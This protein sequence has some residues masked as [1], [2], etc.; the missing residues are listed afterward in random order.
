MTVLYFLA[1]ICCSGLAGLYLLACHPAPGRD[2]IGFGVHCFQ[3]TIDNM[4]KTVLVPINPAGWPLIAI[5]AGVSLLL[6]WASDALGL[7]GVVLTLWCVYFFRDPERFTPTRAG[8]I[9]SP[10]DGRVQLVDR[11]VPPLELDM[12]NKECD[13]VCI[14]MNVF[15]VHVNRVPVDGIIR[16]IAY[17]PGRFLNASLDKASVHN[18][19]ESYLL[20]T[21]TGHHVAFV[22]IAGLVARRIVCLVQEGQ[23]VEAG[24]RFGLIRFGSRVDVYLPKGA[25]PLVTEGQTAVAGETVIADLKAKRTEKKRE[26]RA[27]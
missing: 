10:A 11:A 8:L 18:E 2:I 5:F 1:C 25:V 12:G 15:N 14:F 24:Q 20:E 26:G 16:R 4:L 7:I 19:R 23:P 17:R 3:E 21:D 27:S 22:Q 6:W 9:V 13:R